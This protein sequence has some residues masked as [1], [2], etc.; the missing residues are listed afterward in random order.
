VSRTTLSAGRAERLVEDGG[1]RLVPQRTGSLTGA[2]D[3]GVELL[4][5]QRLQGEM[6]VEDYLKELAK[7]SSWPVHGSRPRKTRLARRRASKRG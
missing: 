7:R 2:F 4:I 1:D 6:S 3:H 5:G